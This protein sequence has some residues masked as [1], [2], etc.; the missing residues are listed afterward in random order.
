MHKAGLLGKSKL[1]GLVKEVAP[2]A[3]ARDDAELGIAE[4]QSK[5]FNDYPLYLDENK[6]FYSALGNRKITDLKGSWNPFE[7]FAGL[8]SIGERI[9]AKNLEGNFRGEGLILGGIVVL[10]G[11]KVVYTYLEDTGK[12]I[13]RDEIIAAAVGK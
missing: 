4:F 10:K 9:K 11:D 1:I 3:T 6:A 2:C 5:Y 8:K 13:P 7:V 12:E